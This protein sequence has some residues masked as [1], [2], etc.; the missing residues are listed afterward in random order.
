[1]MPHE[2]Y[3][4]LKDLAPEAVADDEWFQLSL[5]EKRILTEH[6][7]DPALSHEKLAAKLQC[8]ASA[9][10]KAFLMPAFVRMVNKIGEAR[11][12]SLR[13]LAVE[14]VRTCL[15][16]EKDH[17]V[18]LAGAI[19]ILTDGELLKGTVTTVKQDNK[20]LVL[21]GDGKKEGPVLP[22]K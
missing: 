18:R 20:I 11:M 4:T 19:K 16:Q 12:A 9:V 6:I 15:T 22:E 10:Q 8:S 7:N 5:I 3:E 13:L 17:R 21:W 2:A 1:M 14:A